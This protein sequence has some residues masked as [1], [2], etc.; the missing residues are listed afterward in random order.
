MI[1]DI[2]R[3]LCL[4]D[5]MTFRTPLH[6]PLM[7]SHFHSNHREVE[8]LANVY[9]KRSDMFER[10]TTPFALGHAVKDSVVRIGDLV[11]RRSSVPRLSSRLFLRLLARRRF[12]R[13]PVRRRRQ[14]AIGAVF[15]RTGF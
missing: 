2:K 15:F 12:R 14:M 9:L 11:E 13:K 3:E 8:H 5:E 4:L 1:R 6:F 7:L 10:V